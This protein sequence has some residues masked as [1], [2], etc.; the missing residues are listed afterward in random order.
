M[1]ALPV[2]RLPA[3]ADVLSYIKT[4]SYFESHGEL[5]VALQAYQTAVMH[6]PTEVVL[7]VALGNV[8][9]QRSELAAAR[10]MY[11]RAVNIDGGY[12]PARN[13]L[14]QVLLESGELAEARV[15]AQIAVQSGGKH[16]SQFQ[17]TLRQVEQAQ[18]RQNGELESGSNV[19]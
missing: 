5:E 6:W 19:Q 12:A 2:D 15:H 13:N 9:Y 11:E 8:Y 3:S 4:V 7:L 16:A 18:A 14:A 17:Q 1:V 10:S